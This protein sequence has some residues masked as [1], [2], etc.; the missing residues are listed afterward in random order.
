MSL[1]LMLTWDVRRSSLSRFILLHLSV[2]TETLCRKSI[3]W[4]RWYAAEKS[5][6]MPQILAVWE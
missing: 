2:F 5:L 1:Q 3:S 4:H 6:Y